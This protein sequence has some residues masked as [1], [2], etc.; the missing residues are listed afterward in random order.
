MSEDTAS[1]PVVDGLPPEL[2]RV[3]MVG[4]GGAGM[5][6]LAR[7]LL[8]RGG[9][10]SGSDAKNSRAI[11]EL[12]TRGARVQVGHD[13][14]ALDQIPGGPSVVVT[15][16]AAIP[17]TNP[18]LVAARSRGIPVLLRP[19]VLAQLMVGQRSLLIAGTHGK[20]STTSMAVV[21]LQ[22][23][24]SDPSFAIGG[25]LN[26]SG[27]NAHHGGDPLF[28]A[29]ADE[30]DGS[31]LEYTPDVVVVTNIDADHL[32]FFGSIE[33]YVEVFD[34]FTARITAGG[35]L[36]VCLDDPGSAALA[37]R[38]A[39]PLAERGVTVLGYGRGTHAGLAPTVPNV[40]TLSSWE[41]RGA[42]GVAAVRFDA[43]IR[44][45]PADRQLV[46]P[47]PGEHMA[48][49]AIAAVIGAV[50]VSGP[51]EP[52]AA[53]FD[54]VLAGIGAFGGVHR[55]FEFRGHRGGVEVIDDYAHHPTEVRAVL[56]A[57]QEMM[58]ARGPR[59]GRVIAVFQ[60]HLY[61]RTAEFADEFAA[62]L[63]LA[64]AVV[65]ADVYGAREA[66]IPGV[67]GRTIADKLTV[68][69]LFAPDL[70]RLAGQVAGLARSGD[71][72]LTLGAGDI[73]MQGPEIL[74]ALADGR[75]TDEPDGRDAAASGE[76]GDV[77]G[78]VS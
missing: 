22:H 61:S 5:S 16:H 73:T 24:G 10:V 53:E 67:S 33:A 63:D 40:A 44:P 15:T 6:G 13:P 45:G 49:N 70:S 60:P 54:G 3:H 59:R 75:S 11:L 47:L 21:A 77:T 30:S 66:P 50:R 69:S 2:R 56:S 57:A 19:R 36:I 26:E 37:G 28:V 78:R 38:V 9:Q 14:S 58:S 12:R 43:P 7:I 42:G 65:V 4:I 1:Q 35:S 39:G 8:A 17:K 29:E 51:T 55:R 72:V 32:D 48:L 52:S 46:L 76:P 18:E 34:R 25:E 20:T 62:A 27:T 64:D 68:P 23:A 74:E 41:P 31:L 71:I